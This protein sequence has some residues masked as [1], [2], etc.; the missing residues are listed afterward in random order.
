MNQCMYEPI[1]GSFPNCNGACKKGEN[2]VCPY[3]FE[4]PICKILGRWKKEASV[5]D[6]L[7]ITYDYDKKK[8]IIYTTRPGY[9]IG[10][11]GERIKRYSELLRNELRIKF[12]VSNGDDFIELVECGEVVE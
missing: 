6:A 11:G 4:D 3:Y 1:N 7:L 10:R 5:E 8:L 2:R 12:G 9:L